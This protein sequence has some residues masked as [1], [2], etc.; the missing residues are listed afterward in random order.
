MPLIYTALVNGRFIYYLKKP[1]GF[2]VPEVM[3]IERGFIF[4]RALKAN[5]G[6]KH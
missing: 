6:A 5:S 4:E 1:I 3:I 2:N